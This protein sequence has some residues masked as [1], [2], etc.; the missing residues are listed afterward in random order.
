[1]LS[2]HTSGI[3]KTIRDLENLTKSLE[4]KVKEVAERLLQ[5]GYDVATVM[6]RDA[7]YAGTNDVVVDPPQWEGDTLVLR[8]NGNAVAFIEFGTGMN[9]YEYPEPEMRSKVGAV[10]LGEYGKGHGQWTQWWYK[11][12]AGTGGSK[13]RHVRADG[14]VWYDDVYSTSW[15]NP[16]ARAMFEASRKLNQDHITE[17]AR[18]VFR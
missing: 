15:G 4:D 10:G 3:L 2:I 14:S 12:E 1:M 16:P 9:Y 13:K 18:E 8:A 5:E 7:Q 6:F 17:I 11:G